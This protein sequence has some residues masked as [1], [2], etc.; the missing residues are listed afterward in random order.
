[1]LLY[2]CN[3]VSKFYDEGPAAVIYK[4]KAALQEVEEE[5]ERESGADHKVCVLNFST[6]FV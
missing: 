4:Y 5:A 3:L 6:T 2:L 1:M